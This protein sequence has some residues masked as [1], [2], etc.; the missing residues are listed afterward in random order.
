MRVPN[1]HAFRL[2]IVAC[3]T[4]GEPDLAGSTAVVVPTR[5]AAHHLGRTFAAAGFS[6]GPART[7]FDDVVVPAM[8]TRDDLYVH[9]NARWLG[10]SLCWRRMSARSFSTPPPPRRWPPPRRRRFNRVRPAEMMR[11]YDQLR[12]QGQ[13]VDR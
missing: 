11:F 5:G 3:S 8:L 7:L 13:S 10:R 1:L 9:L 12:R 4:A 6:S 2:A